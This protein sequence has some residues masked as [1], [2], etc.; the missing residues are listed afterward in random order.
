MLGPQQTN[1]RLGPGYT[2]QTQLQTQA[3]N[4]AAKTQMQI[5]FQSQ[6]KGATDTETETLRTL[7]DIV[8]PN[9]LL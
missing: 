9:P 6:L 5:Q 8:K 2:A 4:K 7:L 1:P 3:L